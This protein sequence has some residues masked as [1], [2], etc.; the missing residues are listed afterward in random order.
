M[1]DV[2]SEALRRRIQHWY[3]VVGADRSSTQIHLLEGPLSRVVSVRAA[4]PL[5]GELGL[6]WIW[7]KWWVLLRNCLE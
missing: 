6:F 7:A 4:V 5:S 3:E 1:M 2:Q